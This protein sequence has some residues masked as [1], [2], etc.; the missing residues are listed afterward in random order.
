MK[1]NTGKAVFGGLVGTIA[2]IMMMYWIGPM[3][4]F[5]RMD[6]AQGLGDFLGIGWTAGIILHFVNGTIIFPLIYGLALYQVL[7]GGPVGK[8]LTWGAIL[9]LMAQLG[10]GPP[11]RLPDRFRV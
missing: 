11:V 10:G 9:W 1:P 2:I 4:G 5:M 6:I 7:P 8:G 3:M